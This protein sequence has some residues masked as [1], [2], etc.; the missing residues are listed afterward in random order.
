MAQRRLLDVPGDESRSPRRRSGVRRVL[1]PQLQRS[2]GKSYRTDAAD[3]PGDGRRGRRGGRS[4]GRPRV[5]GVMSEIT[6]ITGRALPMRGDDIDTDRIMP[7]RFL[8][9]ITFDG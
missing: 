6:Q 3:E 4:D 7:A 5:D 1:E 9:A 8:R 2:A